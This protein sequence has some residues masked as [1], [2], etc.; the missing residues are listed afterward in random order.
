MRPIEHGP[1][2]ADRA[3]ARIGGKESDDLLRPRE[4]FRAGCEGLVDHID[5][6]RVD[7]QHAAESGPP[8]FCR[9][10]A[11]ARLVAKVAMDRLNGRYAGR[12]RAD[13]AKAARQ[14]ISKP[15]AAILVTIR[16]R[17]E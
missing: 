4:L 10:L 9:A 1:L 15:I 14:L 5:L 8:H 6:R 2:M 11:Q 12:R 13:E 7:G 17:P 3:R 16:A